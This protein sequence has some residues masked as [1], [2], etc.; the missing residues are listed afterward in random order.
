MGLADF[1]LTIPL[2]YMNQEW[3]S[4]I[5]SIT[6]KPQSSL[7]NFLVSAHLLKNNGFVQ[8]SLNPLSSCL[9][10][11]LENMLISF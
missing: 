8:V 1:A 4:T 3:S 5:T 2:K 9:P 10:T 7:L 11:K 6:P